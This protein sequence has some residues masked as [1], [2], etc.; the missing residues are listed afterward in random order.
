[1]CYHQDLGTELQSDGQG[2]IQEEPGLEGLVLY[3]GGKE[4]ITLPS[5]STPHNPTCLHIS[6]GCF[7]FLPRVVTIVKEG[8]VLVLQKQ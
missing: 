1:M 6:T 3:S 2:H 5:P 7:H 4:L 8:W